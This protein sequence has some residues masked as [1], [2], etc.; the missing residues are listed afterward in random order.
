MIDHFLDSII[1][2][3]DPLITGEEGLKSLEVILGAL[4]SSETGQIASLEKVTK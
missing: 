2:K 3:K 4:R 1:N